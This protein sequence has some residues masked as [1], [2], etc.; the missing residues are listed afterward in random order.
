[1]GHAISVNNFTAPILRI[2]VFS[3]PK[4]WSFQPPSF[5]LFNP[6]VL[7]LTEIVVDSLKNKKSA[8][9]MGGKCLA[10][11]FRTSILYYR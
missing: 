6:Q 11:S 3:T 5:G 7:D 1:M 10:L 8:R 2:L 9:R 4:F